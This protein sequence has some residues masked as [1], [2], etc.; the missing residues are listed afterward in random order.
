VRQYQLIHRLE[1]NKLRNTAKL[2][3]HLLCTDAIPWAVLQARY[4]GVV[5]GCRSHER[6]P[7]AHHRTLHASQQTRGTLPKN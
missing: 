4:G 5:A 1:T 3:A 7:A 6:T 2:F